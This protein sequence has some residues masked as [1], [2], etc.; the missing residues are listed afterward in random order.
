[1]FLALLFKHRHFGLPPKV[2]STFYFFRFVP[3]NMV[4]WWCVDL[5]GAA[6][7][8]VA[9]F[10]LLKRKLPKKRAPSRSAPSGFLRVIQ[11]IGRLINSHDPLRGH[12][13]RHI[14]LHFPRL[15]E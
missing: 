7:R 2:Y 9:F 8:L 10:C 15:I 14:R 11:P 12:V 3:G 6:R 1:M 4:R 5:P 13:L